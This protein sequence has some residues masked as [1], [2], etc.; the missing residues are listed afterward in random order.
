MGVL[1]ANG[2]PKENY[3][4]EEAATGNMAYLHSKDVLALEGIISQG[5]DYYIN[6]QNKKYSSAFYHK[7]KKTFLELQHYRK[8]FKLESTTKPEQLEQEKKALEANFLTNMEEFFNESFEDYRQLLTSCTDIDEISE[9]GLFLVVIKMQCVEYS[10]NSDREK[11]VVLGSSVQK[12]VSLLEDPT[13]QKVVLNS[14]IK[15]MKEVFELDIAPFVDKVPRA[16]RL[17][18]RDRRGIRE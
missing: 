12:V 6:F 18:Q 13:Q 4:E 7:L 17:N 15:Q 1:N 2:E 16:L 9:F 3:A 5:L 8:I 14:I 11:F 10:D